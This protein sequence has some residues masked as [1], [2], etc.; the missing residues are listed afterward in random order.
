MHYSTATIDCS[1]T[2]QYMRNFLASKYEEH[3]LLIKTMMENSKEVYML[4]DHEKLNTSSKRYLCTLEDIDTA[5]TDFSFS[6]DVRN[7]YN[8]VNYIKT[9]M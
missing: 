8:N 6:E 2:A 1:T 4:C 5:I 9:V 7:K 3:I